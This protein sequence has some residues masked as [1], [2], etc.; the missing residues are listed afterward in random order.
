MICSFAAPDLQA[1]GN[2]LMAQLASVVPNAPFEWKLVFIRGVLPN[3]MNARGGYLFPTQGLLE[4][5]DTEAELEFV[6][7]HEIAHQMKG[8]VAAAETR[9]R[10]AE[11]LITVAEVA[12]EVTTG[13]GGVTSSAR[14]LGAQ[15]ALAH[16]DR[17][18]EIEADRIALEIVAAAG[19][20][21]RL[22][23]STL[24]R[25]KAG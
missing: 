11:V 5:F 17:A 15:A 20:D 7:A 25:G 19:Y 18:Q 6:V 21:P 9:Q 3:A 12:T 16:F 13:I 1:Y 2:Q 23:L 4:Q 10:M 14:N 24:E 8:P 22:A